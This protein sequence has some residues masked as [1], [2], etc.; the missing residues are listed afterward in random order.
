MKPILPGTGTLDLRGPGDQDITAR[1]EI[2]LLKERVKALEEALLA[3]EA[4][5]DRLKRLVGALR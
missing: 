4:A 1:M 5:L 2:S 3:Q